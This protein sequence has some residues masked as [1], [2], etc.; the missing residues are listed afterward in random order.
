M[1]I[2]VLGAS[3]MLGHKLVERLALR[4]DVWGTVRSP[5]PPIGVSSALDASRILTDVSV[6]RVDSLI[7]AF[8]IARPDVVLNCIGIVK[9]QAAAKEPRPSVEVNA[10]F[11][12]R[13]AELCDLAGSRL[14]HFSTDCVFSGRKGGYREDDLPD[15]EDIYGRTKLLGEVATT[16]CI[17]IRTSIVGWQL[18][19]ST[20]LLEW[21]ATQQGGRIPG[22]RQAIFSGLSTA[23]LSE[24]IASVLRGIPDGLYHVSAEPIDKYSLLR[25]LVAAL[26]WNID[27]NPVDEPALDRSLDSAA[28]RQAV[29]WKPPS[30]DDMITGLV[31]ERPDYETWRKHDPPA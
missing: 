15:P 29:G 22:H 5:V 16:G 12:H 1:R 17:T 10:L 9:Q 31:N 20:G 8:R 27:V 19:G 2:L 23:A 6:E 11:P 21:L 30:W 24:T 13:L 4:V 28:F 3:G 26:R 7:R 25:Q 18:S 14:I